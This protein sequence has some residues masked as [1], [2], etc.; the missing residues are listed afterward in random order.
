MPES[1]GNAPGKPGLS[2]RWTTSA[3]SGVGTARNLISHVWFTISH[4]I[5]NEIY[6]PRVDLACVRDMGMIVTDGEHYFSEE[7]RHASSVVTSQLEG[8]PAFR[9]VNTSNDGR[10]RI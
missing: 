3:K 9:L 5:L 8:V 6:Y 10:Y 4:G 2:P 1:N 7:K